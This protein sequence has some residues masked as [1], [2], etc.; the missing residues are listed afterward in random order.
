M[1]QLY[2]KLLLG[3]TGLQEDDNTKKRGQIKPTK[4]DT[5]EVQ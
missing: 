3:A 4:K 2:I 5:C 1:Q